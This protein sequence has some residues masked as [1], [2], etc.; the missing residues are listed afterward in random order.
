MNERRKSRRNRPRAVRDLLLISLVALVVFGGLV[1]L[2]LAGP[3]F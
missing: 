3:L 2:A 1:Y